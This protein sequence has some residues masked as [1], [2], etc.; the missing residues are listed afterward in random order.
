MKRKPL[1]PEQKS[2]AI[3]LKAIF[4]SKKKSLGLSQESLAEK[5]GMGQSGVTQLLNGSNAIGPS[6]AAKFSAILGINVEDFSE[7]LAQ[8]IAE[9]AR[10]V[11]RDIT[12]TSLHLTPEQDDLIRTFEALPKDKQEKFMKEMKMM[13][14]HYDAYFEERLK[15]IH[16]NA[17]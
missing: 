14:T 12:P 11:N 2:A 5:M 7:H 15:K 3:K 8:E 10:Y 6:H 17:S 16:D 13:K 4:E 1:T 9:M